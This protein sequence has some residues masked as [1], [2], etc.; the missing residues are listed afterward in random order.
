MLCT[1]LCVLKRAQGSDNVQYSGKG[2]GALY[3]HEEEVAQLF[4]RLRC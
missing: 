1:V 4:L 3:V 2:D